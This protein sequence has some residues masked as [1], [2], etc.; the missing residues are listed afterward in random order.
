MRKALMIVAL[1]LFG[2]STAW[3]GTVKRTIRIKVL[4]PRVQG[5]QTRITPLSRIKGRRWSR[6][7]Y[8]ISSRVRGN[9]KDWKMIY[10]ISGARDWDVKLRFA[11]GKEIPI[12]MDRK[13]S[14]SNKDIPAEEM[15]MFLTHLDNRILHRGSSPVY[16]QMTLLPN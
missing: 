13:V 10:E 11:G 15:E 16:V 1:V 3:A 4:V 5:L 2:V 12:P 6:N 7:S 8:R 9:V 14:F